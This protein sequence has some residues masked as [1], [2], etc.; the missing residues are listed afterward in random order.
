MAQYL[1]LSG[2]HGI[3]RALHAIRLVIRE[4]SL[5]M[6]IVIV[7]GV[8]TGKSLTGVKNIVVNDQPAFT[9][10][11]LKG[12]KQ[13]YRLKEKDMFV[14]EKNASGKEVIMGVQWDFWNKVK[15][16][17][18]SFSIYLDEFQMLSNSR[19]GMSKR[20]IALNEWAAQIRKITNDSFTNNLFLI[21]QRPR[22][23]DIG[24][25]DL[26]SAWVLCE[27]VMHPNGDVY[28]INHIFREL[29]SLESADMS[30]CLHDVFLAN[31]YYQ[32]FDTTKLVFGEKEYL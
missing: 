7:G 1:L 21:T 10:F 23:I 26:A 32:Y 12:I 28:I 11:A 18:P 14:M 4:E 29:E 13:H 5:T 20:S 25:R 6:I 22:S 9:N 24:F 8:G 30:V 19:R 17:F 16:D 3:S 2:R 15:D 27:K 31:P